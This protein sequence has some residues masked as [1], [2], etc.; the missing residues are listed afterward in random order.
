MAGNYPDAPDNRIPY[1]LDGTVCAVVSGTSVSVQSSGVIAALNDESNSEAL[2]TQS[3]VTLIFPRKMDISA[4]AIVVQSDDPGYWSVGVSGIETSVDTATG[5]DGTWISRS[6]TATNAGI[7]TQLATRQN[8]VSV[9]WAG[10]RAVRFSAFS[11]YFGNYRGAKWQSIHLF[12]KPTSGEDTNRLE[13]WHPTLSQRV[14]GA[15]FDWGNAQRSSVEDRQFRVKNLSSTFTA[16]GVN[17]S[18][19]TLTDTTP[20]VPAQHLLSSDGINFSS[21][22]NIG[23][24]AP[25]A[26]SS[27]ITVRR[28]IPSNATLS[29]WQ[30][31]IRAVAASWS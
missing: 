24:L 23:T 9:S 19:D 5:V 29:L 2:Y 27:P 1:D 3:W 8:F 10:I 28:S 22:L 4:Y 31:R 14:G 26:L 18:F 12:G 25:G 30:A 21:T 7:S 16:N 6:P 13:I 20:S 11:T 15:Y 17:L